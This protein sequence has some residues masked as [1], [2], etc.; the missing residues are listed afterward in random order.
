MTT[1]EKFVKRLIELAPDG[2]DCVNDS[3]WANVGTLRFQ[4]DDSFA[5]LVEVRYQFN[6]SYATFDV[7]DAAGEEL[8]PKPHGV[9]YCKYDD[10][11]ESQVARIEAVVLEQ[12]GA[13][14]EQAS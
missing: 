11:F 2:V 12:I 4:P 9:G 5:P 3:T 8:I 14:I 13:G 6:S 10:T 7:R 1:Q